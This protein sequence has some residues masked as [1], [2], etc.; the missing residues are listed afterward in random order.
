VPDFAP[1]ITQTNGHHDPLEAEVTFG[2]EKI[3]ELK[4]VTKPPVVEETKTKASFHNFASR[5][6]SNGSIDERSL[7]RDGD[8]GRQGRASNSGARASEE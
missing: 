6:F 3:D 7:P 5:T 4:V 2:D 8:D 1:G